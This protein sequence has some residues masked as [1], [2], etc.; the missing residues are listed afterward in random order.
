MNIIRK[1]IILRPDPKRVLFR[2]FIPK[3]RKQILKIIARILQLSEDEVNNKYDEIISDFGKRHNEVENYFL[4]QFETVKDLIFTDQ[5]LSEK[6][7]LLI[8]AYFTLEYSFESSALFNPSMIWHPD[9]T[10]VPAGSKRFILSLR[11]IGEGHISS[12][13]FR[14]GRVDKV[15]NI[16]ID[17][18]TRFVTYADIIPDSSYQKDLFTKK[19][20]E[21][22]LFNDFTKKV[23]DELKIY[24]TLNE[25]KEVLRQVV[26]SYSFIFPNAD[27][28]A[29]KI[30]NLAKSNYE[31]E[32]PK[33]TDISERVIFPSTPNEINGIEDARFCE[34]KDEDGSITY[35]ATYTAYDGEVVFPQLLETKD[36]YHFKVNTLNGPAVQ[37]KGMALFPK[38]INGHY[39]M[40]SRQD[41]E[42]IYIMFSDMIHFWYHKKLLLRPTYH[43]EFVQIGNS[44]SPIETDYGW[45]VLYHGVG[46][47][48]KY[49]LGAF[50]LDKEDPTKVI[51]R[52][53]E[54]ILTANENEREGYVPNV[55]Y[56][57]GE[58]IFEGN[59]IIPYAMSDYASS[60]AI[61]PLEDIINE[62]VKV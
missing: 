36:F 8:G 37:N 18:P 49:S 15:G 32:F 38:K 25:L 4:K 2:P 50:L 1:D 60:F 10:N 56:T 39:A 21:L 59:L 14:Q 43:W 6:R 16:S 22:G 3:T 40:L 55:I 33:D 20:K 9:Q 26:K 28:I 54:P 13:T 42:N 47:M 35:Y 45:L 48:R 44:G 7:K 31:I 5:N 34:F 61:V 30:L 52:T 12:I 62:M 51:G 24:F 41:G 53:K 17:N 57:C 29:S 46:A 19:L 58:Q 11:A 23:L 27:V